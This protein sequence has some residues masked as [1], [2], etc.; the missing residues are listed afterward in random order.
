M[1]WGEY[2]TEAG[3]YIVARYLT[4]KPR[5]PCGCRNSRQVLHTCPA[6]MLAFLIGE[7]IE[8]QRRQFAREAIMY[9]SRHDL[10]IHRL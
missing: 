1:T 10:D 4:R 6:G 5:L 8:T 2:A 9:G 7:A 3:R